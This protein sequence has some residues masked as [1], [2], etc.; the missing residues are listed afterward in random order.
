MEYNPWSRDIE[1]NGLLDTCK[2][3]GIAVVA[4]SPLGR[5]FLISTIRFINDLPQSDWRRQL[6]PRFQKE[7]LEK[8]LA[9]V[10][11]FKRISERKGC[12][13]G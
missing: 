10:D 5:G 1:N 2:E 4:Y 3:L 7:A 11:A 12:T 6:N 8:N 9:L 13:T